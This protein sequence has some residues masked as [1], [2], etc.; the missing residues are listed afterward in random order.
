MGGFMYFPVKCGRLPREKEQRIPA[1]LSDRRQNP[2]PVM[3]ED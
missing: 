3:P 1:S 2:L